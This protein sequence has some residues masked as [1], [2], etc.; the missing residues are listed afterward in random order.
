EPGVRGPVVSRRFERQDPPRA[1]AAHDERVAR[2]RRGGRRHHLAHDRRRARGG[3][4]H[5]R[6]GERGVREP[7]SGSRGAGPEAPLPGDGLTDARRWTFAVGVAMALV[8]GTALAVKIRPQID[9]LG[10]GSRAPDF[11]AKNLATGRATT[12]ADYRGQVVL[13]NLWAT[14]CLPCRVEMPSPRDSRA[15][16]GRSEEHTSELQSP[17]DLVCRLLLEK[18]KNNRTHRNM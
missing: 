10:V 13:L 16:P 5:V 8:F 1:R 14:W 6:R 17:Y 18:R 2:L 11:H 4:R 15:P 7:G 9:L 12:L 3:C